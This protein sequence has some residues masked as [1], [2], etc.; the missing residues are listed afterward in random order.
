VNLWHAATNVFFSGMINII[1][2]N[3][4]NGR[5]QTLESLCVGKLSKS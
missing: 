4:I 5:A 3:I 2:G 1:D